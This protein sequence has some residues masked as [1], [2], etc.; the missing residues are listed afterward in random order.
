M[1]PAEYESMV[2]ISPGAR[3]ELCL[4]LNFRLEF[5]NQTYKAL[6]DPATRALWPGL[7]LWVLY[8]DSAPWNIIYAAW[9]IEARA[10]AANQPLKFH[11]LEGAHHF[12]RLLPAFS[13]L[14][15]LL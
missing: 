15:Q 7:E 1:T 8:G 10:R 3:S 13:L 4:I 14:A 6:F 5:A 12:V 9:E 2:D 11:V